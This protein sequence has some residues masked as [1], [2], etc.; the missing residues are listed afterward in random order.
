MATLFSIGKD[1]PI[2]AAWVEDHDIK[3]LLDKY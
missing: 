1:L 3:K 2:T